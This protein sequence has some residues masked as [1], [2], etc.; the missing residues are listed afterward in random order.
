MRIATYNVEWFTNLFAND[1]SLLDDD[2]WSGRRDV[3][4]AAQLAALGVVFGALDSDAVMIIEAPD[5]HRKRS[6]VEALQ[7]L[8]SDFRFARAGRLSVSETTRS[9]RLRSCSIR[10]A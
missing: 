9:R 1:G 6:G 8:P 10:I 2:R 3:T 5:S 4:R 7:I